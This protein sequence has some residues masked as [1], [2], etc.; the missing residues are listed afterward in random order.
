MTRAGAPILI[1]G[2]LPNLFWHSAGGM[3]ML[4]QR[5]DWGFMAH[6]L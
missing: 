3:S 5:W 2:F 6:T 4:T 1:L